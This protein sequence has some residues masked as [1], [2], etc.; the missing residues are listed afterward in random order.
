MFNLEELTII[1]PV[2]VE[3][4][5]RYNNL[6]VV[7]GYINNHFKTNVKIIEE[8]PDKPKVDFLSDFINLNID[9]KFYCVEGNKPYHRTKYLNEML[10]STTTKVVSNYDSDVFF[11]VETYINVVNSIINN[12][13]DFVYPY[14]FGD[15]QKQLYYSKWY[16]DPLGKWLYYPMYKFTEDWN[17][18]I[19]ESDDIDDK[20]RVVIQNS[21]CGHSIFANTE[22]YKEAFGENENF[23]SYGPEDQERLYRFK[24]LGYRLNWY[25][26]FVYHIEHE[27]T[28]D[29]NRENPMF[30]S[31]NELFEYIKSLNEK[32]LFEYYKNINYLKKYKLK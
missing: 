30:N 23:I 8:S 12:E 21:E 29:S 3:S 28:P 5:D 14:I 22:K 27:R 10:F 15:G 24:K 13:Y 20:K 1:I 11:P 16:E 17:P 18:S 9:Y 31:N 4:N 7:L 19:F 2:K 25:N 6:K 32:E 26:D